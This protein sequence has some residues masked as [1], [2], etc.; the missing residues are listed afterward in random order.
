MTRMQVPPRKQVFP[1]QL[2]RA[3]L[4]DRAMGLELQ[5][6]ELTRLR[7]IAVDSGDSVSAHDREISEILRNLASDTTACGEFA[8]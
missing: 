3:C 7:A 4:A 2:S 1:W 6:I 5:L 8:A